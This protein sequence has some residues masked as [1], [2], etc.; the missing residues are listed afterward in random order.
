MPASSP[1]LAT[2][3]RPRMQLSR[4]SS[5][6]SAAAVAGEGDDVGRFG[7]GG[8]GDVVAHVL[9]QLVVV[10]LAVPG[11]GNVAGAGDDGGHQAVFGAGGPVLFLH[12]VEAAEAEFGGLTAQV[13]HGD[14]AV[15]PARGGLLEASGGRGGRRL[16]ERGKGEARTD[17]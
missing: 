5:S 1:I 12:Q 3:L 4:P 16:G 7:G 8:F 15:A 2:R 11:H 13:V 14:L 17:E 6:A 9:F 10:L